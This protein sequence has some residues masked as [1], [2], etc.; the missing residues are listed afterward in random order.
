MNEAQNYNLVTIEQMSELLKLEPYQPYQEENVPPQLLR[1]EKSGY[2]YTDFFR[3]FGTNLLL[4]HILVEQ[5]FANH[6]Q[7][8]WSYV[9]N[10]YEPHIIFYIAV[11]Y[12][13]PL[14]WTK[15]PD[16]V[17]DKYIVTGQF[18]QEILVDDRFND[19]C[20]APLMGYDVQEKRA[21]F[22]ADTLPAF[23][24]N[25]SSPLEPNPVHRWDLFLADNHEL[26]F[27][28]VDHKDPYHQ[29]YPLSFFDADVFKENLE[30]LSESKMYEIICLLRK[31]WNSI[32]RQRLFGIQNEEEMED[33]HH[34]LFEELQDFIERYESRPQESEEERKVI[35]SQIA[36][37][38][39]EIPEPNKY[40]ET[41]TY[42]KER[43]KFDPGFKQ[44][45]DNSTYDKKA[46][47]LSKIFGWTLDAD[48]LR[49]RMNYHK[50]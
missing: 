46:N 35:D 20:F 39:L 40:R 26:I 6:E 30:Y 8:D 16:D 1:D 47:I 13:H 31:E 2:L 28:D 43:S 29:E 45:M 7:V 42:I 3:C 23:Q 9:S 24:P 4:S 38:I 33:F 11:L 49:I 17:A 37:G 5:L 27:A 12:T 19:E 25:S 44:L 41:V 22:F 15:I 10:N 50:K 36:V 34:Y 21:Q 48:A 14:V 32:V 18:A